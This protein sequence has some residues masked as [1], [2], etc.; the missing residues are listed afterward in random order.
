LSSH[1]I[2]TSDTEVYYDKLQEATSFE[3]I[4]SIYSKTSISSS[5]VKALLLQLRNSPSFEHTYSQSYRKLDFD[6]SQYQQ[7]E[8]KTLSMIKDAH[9][10][11]S[12]SKIKQ[13]L[14]DFQGREMASKAL[15]E[16]H[17]EFLK[18]LF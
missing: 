10:K 2:I 17:Y 5:K 16:L 8:S 1:K 14:K 11:L 6:Y 12:V 18:T 13:K 9:C 3:Q 4:G 15:S 7:W